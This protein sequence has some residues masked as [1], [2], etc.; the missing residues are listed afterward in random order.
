M[1]KHLFVL[2]MTALAINVF[3][4]GKGDEGTGIKP[5]ALEVMIFDRGNLPAEYGTVDENVW[6]KWIDEKMIEAH[7]ITVDFTPVIRRQERDQLNVLMASGDA[8]DIIY[9]YYDDLVL[10]YVG[11]G[12]LADLTNPMAEMGSNIR[13]LVGDDVLKK[14]GQ[15][16]GKQLVIPGKVAFTGIFADY[17][18]KDWLDAVGLEMPTTTDEWYHAVKT[19]VEKDPGNVGSENIIGWWLDVSSTYRLGAAYSNNL[20]ISFV[21]EMTEEE[22]YS[23]PDL[24]KPGYK[25][26]VRFF[27]KLYNEGL[28]NQDFALE[29]DREGYEAAVSNG[30]I[31]STNAAW[32]ELFRNETVRTLVENNPEAYYQAGTFF[33]NYEGKYIREL[34][35]PVGARIMVPVFSEALEEAVTYLDWQSTEEISFYLWYGE[36]GSHHIMTKDGIPLLLSLEERRDNNPFP[37]INNRDMSLVRRNA[38]FDNT[39]AEGLARTLTEDGLAL[40]KEGRESEADMRNGG[41]SISNLDGFVP[42]HFP[43]PLET[44]GR[45]GSVLLEKHM[46]TVIRATVAKPADFD[47]TW[48]ALIEEFLQ[49]GGQ[50]VIDERL[51]VYREYIK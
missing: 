20:L 48:D 29:T 9:T 16:E 39:T 40:R 28:I 35:T 34:R 7:N 38:F 42:P 33:D 18:R 6:T 4:N 37:F 23:L 31:V 8:P 32:N 26:G 19:I 12:G 43:V 50:E 15:F 17:I 36:E 47:A 46:E 45:Y 3:G 30:Y 11:Q 21:E 2:L 41:Q 5:S 27:N 24:L 13:A 49:A 44:T 51:S 22:W 14:Y 25:E 1:K 10:S